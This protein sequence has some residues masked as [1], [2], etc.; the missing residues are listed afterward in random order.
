MR[1]VVDS[2]AVREWI[3]SFPTFLLYGVTQPLPGTVVDSEFGTLSTLLPLL[4]ATQYVKPRH[5]A[6]PLWSLELTGSF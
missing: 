2:P 6:Q 4:T 5:Q 3:G 1:A